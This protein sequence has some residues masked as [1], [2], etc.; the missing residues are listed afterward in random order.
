MNN[1]PGAR[2]IKVLGIDRIRVAVSQ[3]VWPFLNAWLE[4]L[5]APFIA[6][7]QRNISQI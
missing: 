4:L 1:Q 6:I 2:W 7:D 3:A 5:N